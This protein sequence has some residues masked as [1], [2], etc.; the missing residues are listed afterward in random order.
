MTEE[1]TRG[2]HWEGRGSK[3]EWGKLRW[4]FSGEGKTFCECQDNDS[5]YI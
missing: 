4:E 5:V 1:Y 3:E 2:V